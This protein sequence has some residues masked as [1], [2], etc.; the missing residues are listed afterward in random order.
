M[1]LFS[2]SDSNV[3]S[4][5]ACGTT[6]LALGV[7]SQVTCLGLGS[8]QGGGRQT[9][10]HRQLP[11]SF[12]PACALPLSSFSLRAPHSLSRIILALITRLSFSLCTGHSTGISY[13]FP[14]GCTCTAPRR[15]GIPSCSL[16]TLFLC[17]S[18]CVLTCVA[19]QKKLVLSAHIAKMFST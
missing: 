16:S 7:S 15:G 13:F 6:C 3:G 12:V 14:L 8:T 9:T 4:E 5:A 19:T 18:L 17:S 11:E 2:D 10:L 1:C